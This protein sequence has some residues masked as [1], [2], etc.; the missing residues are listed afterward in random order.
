V[1]DIS[2]L[3]TLRRIKSLRDIG[4]FQN[5]IVAPT[6]PNLQRY[7]LIYGFNGTGKTTLSRLL[8]Q[9]DTGNNFNTLPH[10]ARF[11][12]EL[13]DNTVVTRDNN[14]DV[15]TGRLL[16]FNDEFVTENL[17]W[18]EGRANPVFYL[19]AKTSRL[20]ESL[21][22]IEQ[23]IPLRQQHITIAEAEHR[24]SDRALN[25]FYTTHARVISETLGLGRQYDT[26]H[27]KQDY[28]SHAYAKSSGLSVSQR[29]NLL[30]LINTRHAFRELQLV[31]F[32]GDRIGHLFHRARSIC[33]SSLKSIT[34]DALVEHPS[35]ARWAKEGLDYHQQQ[36][37]TDCVF[38]GSRLTTERLDKLQDS[39]G[40]SVGFLLSEIQKIT[41][42][43][44]G[45][46]DKLRNWS[47]HLPADQSISPHYVHAYR[48]ARASI[49]DMVANTQ[50]LIAKAQEALSEKAQ[51]L[52]VSHWPEQLTGDQII[53]SV[54]REMEGLV[55]T[56]NGLIAEHNSQQRE[57]LERQAQA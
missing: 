8:R 10:T 49:E 45:E 2:P 7:N 52:T 38:C 4:I 51:F 15:L 19:G 11:E 37:L 53:E 50:G 55:V 27:L 28:L 32:D 39:L 3:P 56:V 44:T 9:L 26:R 43:L 17:R 40:D 54:L 1:T 47:C 13:T 25:S 14:L 23:H 21:E 29:Q 30:I 22:L 5:Y 18:S 48:D 12:I 31:V 36:N 57:F 46:Q 6:T 42:Q 20:S 24:A 16:V 34:L 41:E 35:M 33:E